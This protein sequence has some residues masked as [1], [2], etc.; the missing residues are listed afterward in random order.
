[1]G[2]QQTAA[3]PTATAHKG[4]CDGKRITETRYYVTS[5][6]SSAKALLLH[7]RDRL[8]IENSW[9]WPRDTQLKEDDH[10][11]RKPNDMQIMATLRCLA[12]N[13]LR[14]DGR[15]WDKLL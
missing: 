2:L 12:M 8:S 15:W 9:H 6:S 13:T 14:L 1:M 11:Y 7:V 5:L 4:R 3:P 10:C